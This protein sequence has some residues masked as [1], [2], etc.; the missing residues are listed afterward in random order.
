[1]RNGAHWPSSGGMHDGGEFLR[2]RLG[3]VDDADVARGDGA[4]EGEKIGSSPCHLYSCS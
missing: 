3:E 1:M 4:G 2:E